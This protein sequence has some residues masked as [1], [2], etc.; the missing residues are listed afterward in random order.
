MIKT[1][2]SSSL[3]LSFLKQC[4]SDCD[5]N[6]RR[7]WSHHERQISNVQNQLKEKCSKFFL[8]ALSALATLRTQ[9][10]ICIHI[11]D[12]LIDVASSDP[13]TLRSVKAITTCSP[14]AGRVESVCEETLDWF[15]SSIISL[16]KLLLPS[17][18]S[19]V[20]YSGGLAGG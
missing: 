13:E 15:P 16:L 2:E 19:S 12:S 20:C 3:Q 18:S 14:V 1:T 6:R 11:V 5:C 8:L 7:A 10:L 9:F 4:F 17:V